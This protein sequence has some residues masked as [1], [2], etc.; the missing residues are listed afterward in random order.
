MATVR[1]IARAVDAIA[2][3]ATQLDWDNSGLLIGDPDREAARVLVA[4]D[5]TLEVI[6]RAQ[7]EGAEVVVTHHPV[8]FHG[9]KRLLAGD[10]PYEAAARGIAVISAHT[11]YDMAPGG[12]NDALADALDL[13]DR[14]PLHREEDGRTLGVAGDLPEEMTREALA[15]WAGERL[16]QRPGFVRFLPGAG[17]EAIRRMAVCGGAGGD[18]LREAKELGCQAYLTGEVR[19]H[20]FLAAAQMG[21]LLM[22]AGHFAT[23]NIAVPR[24][25][26][27]LAARLAGVEVLTAEA[28]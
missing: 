10:P 14:R 1:D 18:F 24:L 9:V 6:R 27:Q 13:R 20:E 7:K 3:F 8:I 2:P 22:D 15:A 28:I 26:A 23:E 5:A 11:C 16:G 21:L 4:L 17:P 19:H 25:A 12:V